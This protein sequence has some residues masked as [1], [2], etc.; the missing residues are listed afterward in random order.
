M[1][2]AGGIHCFAAHEFAPP[3]DAGTVIADI[4]LSE[5]ENAKRGTIM[6]TGTNEWQKH[7]PWEPSPTSHPQPVPLVKPS[8]LL[9]P[10]LTIREVMK[11]DAPTCTVETSVGEA[12]KILRDSASSAVFVLNDEGHPLGVLTDRAVA[13]AVLDHGDRLGQLRVQEVMKPHAPTVPIDSHLDVLL[14]QFTNE[15]VAVV[16]KHG[17]IQ[18]VVRWLELL[19]PLSERALGKLV[20]NLFSSRKER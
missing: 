16:D 17:R 20:A 11:D 5:T 7:H 1:H 15:G 10:F 14:D 19:G 13:L 8:D 6:P 4:S 3:G 2:V 12:V 9:N 18:G